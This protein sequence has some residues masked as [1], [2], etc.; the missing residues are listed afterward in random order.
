[1]CF[2]RAE[3]PLEKKMTQIDSVDKQMVNLYILHS[4]APNKI[5]TTS[6]FSMYFL[7][8]YVMNETQKI[9]MNFDFFFKVWLASAFSH[10]PLN[11]IQ[12][13]QLHLDVIYI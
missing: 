3:A 13:I 1:M 6:K 8:L 5:I 4:M 12:G 11:K 10:R 2:H 7:E 9:F